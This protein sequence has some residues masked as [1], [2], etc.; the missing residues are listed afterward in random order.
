MK[1]HMKST[2]LLLAV[3]VACVAASLQEE[4]KRVGVFPK[5]TGEALVNPDRSMLSRLV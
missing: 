3:S 1:H 5:D 4:A 2:A